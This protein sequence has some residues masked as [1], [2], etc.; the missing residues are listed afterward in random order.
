MSGLG[1]LGEG[2]KETKIVIDPYLKAL[3]VSSYT[4][5]YLCMYVCI[6]NALFPRQSPFAGLNVQLNTAALWGR[7]IYQVAVSEGRIQ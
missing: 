3:D 1:A 2:L 4:H 5:H 6:N 7:R